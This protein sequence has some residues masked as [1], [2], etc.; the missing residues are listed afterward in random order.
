MAREMART[1]PSRTLAAHSLTEIAMSPSAILLLRIRRSRIL[2]NRS[3][4]NDIGAVACLLAV[5]A[6]RLRVLDSCGVKIV[7]KTTS[8]G[9]ERVDGGNDQIRPFHVTPVE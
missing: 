5:D 9:L 6:E 3:E 8:T 7:R 2:Q 1:S 4:P